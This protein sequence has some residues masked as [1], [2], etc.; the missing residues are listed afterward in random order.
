V[1]N[2]EPGK[3]LVKVAEHQLTEYPKQ[4]RI[5]NKELIAQIMAE[6]KHCLIEGYGRH[7]GEECPHHIKSR[8]SG[9]G[10]V[11]GNI[12]RVCARHHAVIHNGLISREVLYKILERF[13]GS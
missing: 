1:G 6:Q 2:G 10:D 11:R 9:G 3:R 8:G 12:L 13:Y 5:V 4:K 7:Y